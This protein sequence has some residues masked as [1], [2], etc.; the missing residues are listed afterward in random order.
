MKSILS[1]A[2][3][4]LLFAFVPKAPVQTYKINTSASSIGWLGK[5][6]GGQHNGQI[7]VASGSLVLDNGKISGGQFAID[8][9]SITCEDI[10]DANMNAR[11]VGHLKSDDFF[12]SEKHPTASFTITEAKHLSKN[13]TKDKY[14][15]KGNLEIKGISSPVEFEAETTTAGN[16]VTA[17]AAFAINRA[18][19]NIQYR[20]GSFF[21]NLGDK[22]IYD[23]IELTLNTVFEL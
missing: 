2:I 9:Q 16:K 10:K 22:L 4:A 6:V 8:M 1:L 23:D 20:S 21:E 18:K 3:V 14:Q 13:G 19:W 7:K 12:S 5:K 17:V 15:I 11:L